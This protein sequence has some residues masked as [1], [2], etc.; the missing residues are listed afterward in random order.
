MENKKEIIRRLENSYR[1]TCID[2]DAL[3]Y[4]VIEGDGEYVDVYSYCRCTG[5]PWITVDVTA[6][7]GIAMIYDVAKAV[8]RNL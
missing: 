1:A 3:V 4:H 5:K 2:I 7:S 6:D 8:M